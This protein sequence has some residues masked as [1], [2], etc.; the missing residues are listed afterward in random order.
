MKNLKE[1][2]DF[3]KATSDEDFKDFLKFY[4]PLDSYIRDRKHKIQQAEKI[5]KEKSREEA[6][7]NL[8]LET[9][10]DGPVYPGM[11]ES[12]EN[13]RCVFKTQQQAEDL[14]KALTSQYYEYLH[15]LHWEGPGVYI[16]EPDY[17]YDRCGDTIYTANYV[18]KKK[19]KV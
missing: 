10:W 18:K 16:I 15:K 13:G 6:L 1:Y 4:E 2:E 3:V 8:K 19:E 9:K 11:G 14:T 12:G 5:L 17:G 7:R